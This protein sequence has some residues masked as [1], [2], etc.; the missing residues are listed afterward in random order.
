MTKFIILCFDKIN[1][2][3]EA[4]MSQ[5]SRALETLANIS[6]VLI[7][8][9]LGVYLEIFVLCGNKKAEEIL[10]QALA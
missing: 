4:K 10:H 2:Q 6:L 5:E 8:L 3:R 7:G 9:I 1:N